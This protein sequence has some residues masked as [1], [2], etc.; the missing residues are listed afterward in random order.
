[1]NIGML[2][3]NML[4]SVK[5]AFIIILF[6]WISFFPAPV[7]G[8]YAVFTRIFLGIFLLILVLGKQ[9]RKHIFS[10]KD[11]P[12]WL[13][14]ACMFSGTISATDKDVAFSTFFY[15][16]ITFPL[17]FY[18]G[19]AIYASAESRKRVAIIICICASMVALIGFLE[20]Y[21]AKNLLY[22]YFVDNPYYERYINQELRPMS[23]QFNPVIFGSYLLACLPFSFY[24]FKEKKAYLRFL[25][26]GCAVLLVIGIMFSL[27]RGVFLG[28]VALSLFYM[29]NKNKKKWATLFIACL[30]LFVM[31]CTWLPSKGF[32]R[33]GFRQMFIGTH[34]GIISTYRFRRIDMTF[35]I[36]KDYPLFGIG[37]NH[38]RIRFNE[39]CYK[40]D[41]GK[42]LN[43]FMI[44]DNMYLSFLSETGI[45]GTAGFLTFILFLLNRWFRK[46]KI[47]EGAERKEASLI[48][49]A[50]LVGLFVNMAAYD[51]FYW[52]TPYMF[53]CL[54][55]GS[56][57]S[58]N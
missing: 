51:M 50:A 23:T 18:I 55:S 26:S 19:K 38:F 35:R 28:L 22:E 21:F 15:I 20:L 33:F 39:Y 10:L 53:F 27:S 58:Y 48:V 49:M 8:Q 1:M 30:I 17:L 32:S 24:L 16:V 25:G 13:F 29:W 54:L 37:F 47:L 2:S 7:Q 44:P 11:W 14:L 40:E 34:R 12:L 57:Q 43:E 31:L 56:M 36:L 3:I 45:V 9:W 6:A 4:R 41:V 52:H 42:V 46:F 5:T